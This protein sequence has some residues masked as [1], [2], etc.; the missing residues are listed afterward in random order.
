MVR[1]TFANTSGNE[2]GITVN[3]QVA[4]V[5]GNEFVVNHLPV[6][7]GEN[8]ITVTATDVSSFITQETMS[9]NLDAQQ[10]ERY[11]RITANAESG[12]PVFETT[13]K[14]DGSFNFTDQAISYSGP[15]VVEF[16]TGTEEN[17]YPISISTPGIYYFTVTA[18][19]ESGNS[20]SD[21]MAIVV[22]DEAALDGL[23]RAK[24]AGMKAALMAGDI[25]HAVTY[26]ASERQNAYSL[27]F[28][29][30]SDNIGDIIAATGALESFE[31]SDNQARYTISY[32][33]TVD[34]IS[35]T[36]GTYVIFLQD[37]DGVWRIRF[38]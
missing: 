1:G 9:I 17:S 13:L 28:N 36:A 26:F 31:V 3:G 18:M 4:M 16:L 32:P 27:V 12:A 6:H 37:T 22:V 24:W 5:Y 33:I 23:L 8:T 15:G 21:T 25:Q 14:V 11:I 10:A 30:L 35:T 7:D 20:Y 38:F 34:G 29:D 2:T 19:D